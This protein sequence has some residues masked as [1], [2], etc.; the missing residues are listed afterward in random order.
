MKI[1]YYSKGKAKSYDW[2]LVIKSQM[3]KSFLT[4]IGEIIK[5]RNELLGIND[6]HIISKTMDETYGDKSN[7][8][9]C[10]KCGMCI[11]CGDCNCKTP[12]IP[13][14]AQNTRNP[15]K[16]ENLNINPTAHNIICPY[17]HGRGFKHKENCETIR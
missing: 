13:G 5:K 15:G 8:K 14:T 4:L 6:F 7:H 11:D 16:T 17:C 12:A 2:R 3:G 9:C 10:D 1:N